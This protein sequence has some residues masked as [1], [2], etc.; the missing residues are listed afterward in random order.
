MEGITQALFDGALVLAVFHV[1]E[2]DDDQAADVT[3]A[4][5]AGDF[6]GRFQVGLERGLLDV[7]ALGGARGVDVDRGQRFG[8]AP[9]ICDSI[10]KRLNS[11]MS[12]L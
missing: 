7:A 5:L 12:S 2:V 10:W 8:L 6:L 11:G 1:D 3:Q 9:S 4:Q